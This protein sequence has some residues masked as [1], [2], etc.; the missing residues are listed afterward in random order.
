MTTLKPGMPFGGNM[1]GLTPEQRFRY[2][3]WSHGDCW[4][5]GAALGDDGYGRFH[6]G[7]GHRQM[8]R[9]HRFAYE[10]A[11]GT[12]PA[13]YEIHHICNHSQC[14]RPSHLVAM[15]HGEHS[16]LSAKKRWSISAP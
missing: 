3:V 1:L 6:F 16:A 2:K 14:V 5:W 13:G 12:I 10:M 9:A 4:F 8:V 11:K 15:K 7:I